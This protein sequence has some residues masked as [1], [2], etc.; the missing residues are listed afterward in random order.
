MNVRL[1][2]APFVTGAGRLSVLDS[3]QNDASMLVGSAATLSLGN[4]GT[5]TINGLQGSNPLANI[6]LEIGRST[7]FISYANAAAD[8]V[9]N[10][11][12]YLANGYAAGAWS[13]APTPA[14]GV[15][16]SLAANARA[17]PST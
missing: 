2:L 9:A 14:A 7:V 3:V 6:N 17:L 16:T 12:N 10:I 13:G 1:P 4:G 15:I 11:K 5:F 8:P